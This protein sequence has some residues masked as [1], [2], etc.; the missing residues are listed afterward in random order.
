MERGYHL[1]TNHYLMSKNQ[2]YVA[3]LQEDGNFVLYN[4]DKGGVA[5]FATDTYKQ[6]VNLVQLRNDGSV[7]LVNKSD[8]ENNLWTSF[9]NSDGDDCFLIMRNDGKLLGFKGTSENDEPY[10][11]ASARDSTTEDK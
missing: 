9:N 1:E 6:P 3:I 4:R 11:E 5:D 10:F 2:Q 8:L 7:V